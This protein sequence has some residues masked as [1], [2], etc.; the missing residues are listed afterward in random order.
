MVYAFQNDA[1][2]K[3]PSEKELECEVEAL[4]ALVDPLAKEVIHAEF[5]LPP[6][7]W[8]HAWYS[9][10]YYRTRVV[11]FQFPNELVIEWKCSNSTPRDISI[12]LL[13]DT[14]PI[15]IPI[16]RMAPPE[17]KELKDQLKDLSDK[18]FIRSSIS[19]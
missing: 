7:D 10:I 19:P 13:R 8:I 12:D 1:S 3:S 2:K 5:R 9:L 15:S 6:S 11:K 16:Y 17:L 14:L 18:G 4:Q